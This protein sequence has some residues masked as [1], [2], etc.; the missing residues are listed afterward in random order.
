MEKKTF[1][2]FLAVEGIILYWVIYFWQDALAQIGDYRYFSYSLYEIYTLGLILVPA[3]TLIWLLVLLRTCSR[4]KRWKGNMILLA[5]L[6]VLTGWQIWAVG[7]ET[8][9]TSTMGFEK[10]VL[11]IPDDYHIVIE[12]NGQRLVLETN[13]QVTALVKTD[14]TLYYMAYHQTSRD[15][16]Y[17]KLEYI[18]LTETLLEN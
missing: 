8:G 7:Q 11:E 16:K 18:A 5:L 1:R 2:R 12:S 3:A 6:V 15:A 17:G 4:E 14:G 10:Q 13:P 9:G